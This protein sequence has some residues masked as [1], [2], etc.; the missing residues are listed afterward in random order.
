MIN[1]R[2]M[3]K[4]NLKKKK[5]YDSTAPILK[6]H[7]NDILRHSYGACTDRLDVTSHDRGDVNVTFVPVEE[8]LLELCAA[9]E[10]IQ[11]GGTVA[12]VHRLILL[13]R[14]NTR[15]CHQCCRSRR[16]SRLQRLGAYRVRVP[17]QSHRNSSAAH[18]TCKTYGVHVRIQCLN[19]Y[20]WLQEPKI[21]YIK[22]T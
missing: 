14:R 19:Y 2:R 1:V 21:L 16:A 22:L 12:T 7:K 18:H 17:L 4:N 10:H 6:L 9:R 20:S 11:S 15:W 3:L 5:K 13:P 8:I